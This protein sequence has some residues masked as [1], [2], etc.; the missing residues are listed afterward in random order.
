M[1]SPVQAVLVFTIL[2]GFLPHTLL[3]F[4][5]ELPAVQISVVGP[6]GP[7]D[8]AFITFEHHSFVFLF[9]GCTH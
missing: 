9:L 2:M 4:V 5:R 3:V 6:D 7:I 8:G 1:R